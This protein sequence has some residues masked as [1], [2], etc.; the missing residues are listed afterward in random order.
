MRAPQAH[1]VLSNTLLQCIDSTLQALWHPVSAQAVISV[2]APTLQA[3]VHTSLAV[4]W[5]NA[6]LSMSAAPIPLAGPGTAAMNSDVPAFL[7]LAADVVASQAGANRVDLFLASPLCVGSNAV[8]LSTQVPRFLPDQDTGGAPWFPSPSYRLAVHTVLVHLLSLLVHICAQD[9]R[10]VLQPVEHAASYDADLEMFFD[11]TVENDAAGWPSWLGPHADLQRVL[12]DIGVSI[13]QDAVDPAQL[14]DTPLLASLASC[15]RPTC[16]RVKLRRPTAVD[17]LSG[18]RDV[19]PDTGPGG[20]IVTLAQ[21]LPLADM[22]A[23][24]AQKRVAVHA[25]NQQDVLVAQLRMYLAACGAVVVAPT[26]SKPDLAVVVNSLAALH[27]MTEAADAVH[28]RLPP[29]AYFAPISALAHAAASVASSPAAAGFSYFPLPVGSV[30]LLWALFCTAFT[31]DSGVYRSREGVVLTPDGPLPA[32]RDGA[33]PGHPREPRRDAGAV[34]RAPASAPAGPERA[35]TPPRGAC[36]PRR[37]LPSAPPRECADA[38]PARTSDYF[39]EA[40]SQLATQTNTS[41]GVVLRSIDGR[42]AGIFFQPPSEDAGGGGAASVASPPERVN[43]T[44]SLEMD[45][46]AEEEGGGVGDGGGAAARDIVYP[47]PSPTRRERAQ[48]ELCAAQTAQ[49]PRGAAEVAPGARPVPATTAYCARRMRS[50]S[51]VLPPLHSPTTELSVSN[52]MFRTEPAELALARPDAVGGGKGYPVG[53]VLKPVELSTI[54]GVPAGTRGAGGRPHAARA[55]ALSRA[56][57][58]QS[59]RLPPAPELHAQ[60]DPMHGQPTPYSQLSHRVARTSAQPQSG[61]LIGAPFAAGGA[62]DALSSPHRP[63]PLSPTSAL[64]IQRRKLAMREAFLPPVRVLIVEDNVINQRILSTFL[65][66]KHIKYDIAKDGREAIDKWR[67][68]DY[69]LI[70]MDIQLPVLDGIAATKEIRR[71]EDA[72]RRLAQ[73]QGPASPAWPRHSVI[74]VALTASVLTSDRVAAL[75]AGCNDFLNKPV[76]LPWLQ[77][78]IIEWGSMQYL[79]HAGNASVHHD[80]LEKGLLPRRGRPAMDSAFDAK[81]QQVASNLHLNPSGRAAAP[82]GR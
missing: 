10:L 56:G 55:P 79:L 1:K 71:L 43:S 16:A 13:S 67:A 58:P 46:L 24:L 18:V 37:P 45:R 51:E 59:I 21:S 35:L 72:A 42:P 38:S 33:V 50:R 81:A 74:I 36:T 30:R 62:A 78:K 61:L 5:L 17:L 34:S 27:T 15:A 57:A 9:S 52:T 26:D 70:L 82:P 69:H 12:A 47:K 64:R 14:V 44:E 54:L 19:A 75:A 28:T 41:S 2:S 22:Q 20:Q 65:R 77:R 40:V 73:S 8:P 32:P 29:T 76:S 66:K 63:V 39:N 7:Q 6:W 68:G 4:Q 3:V 53:H 25:A 80:A 11:S 31:Y 48:P 23:Y 49:S 60:P